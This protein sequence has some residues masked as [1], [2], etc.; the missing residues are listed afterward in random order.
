LL[1]KITTIKVKFVKRY[2][3]ILLF[4]LLMFSLSQSVFAEPSR[5][6]TQETTAI[7]TAGSISLDL[8]YPFSDLGLTTGLRVAAFDGVVL[9]NS[10]PETGTRTGFATSSS[11]G[12]KKIIQ[13]NI[14]A[15]GVVSY[16]DDRVNS[17]TDIAI[18]AAYTVKSGTLTY[19]INPEFITDEVAGTRALKNTLFVKGSA[20]FPLAAVKIGKAS[21]VAELNLENNSALDSII[22][23]GMRWIPRKDITLDFV[24]YSDRGNP[25]GGADDIEKGIPGWIKANIQF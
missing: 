17:G 18:G 14:A 8:D 13:N 19:N 1:L 6:F 22:N 10:H 11:V 25:G 3:S 23:L 5:V 16:Y 20:M 21:V 4:I 12:F 9:I 2:F 15:Y 7:E 24:L